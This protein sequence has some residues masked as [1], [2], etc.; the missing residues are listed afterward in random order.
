M[1][2]SAAPRPSRRVGGGLAVLQNAQNSIVK[3]NTDALLT[4]EALLAGDYDD[5]DDDDDESY[6]SN[7][8][9]EDDDDDDDDNEDEAT[10]KE[11]NAVS[12]RLPLHA[13][14]CTGQV[15]SLRAALDEGARTDQVKIGVSSDGAPRTVIFDLKHKS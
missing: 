12:T 4:M 11:N 1:R 15:E 3:T 2:E 10:S 14:A 7:K 6:D 13:A 8:A 5:D 9:E